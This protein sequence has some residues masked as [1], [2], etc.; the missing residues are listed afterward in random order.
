[1]KCIHIFILLIV[2]SSVVF[3][4]GPVEGSVRL[5]GG[6]NSCEGKFILKKKLLMNS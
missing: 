2:F 3:G 6:E 1:M 5:V 4:R